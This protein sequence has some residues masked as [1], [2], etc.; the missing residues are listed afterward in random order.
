LRDSYDGPVRVEYVAEIDRFV[1]EFHQK[2]GPEIGVEEA[3]GLLKELEQRF[4]R[5]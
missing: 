4:D 3:Y 5:Q 1:T 2:H